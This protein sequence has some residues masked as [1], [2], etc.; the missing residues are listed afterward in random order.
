VEERKK[1]RKQE[2]GTARRQGSGFRVQ[3]RQK[4]RKQ[5][6]GSRNCTPA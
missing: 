6:A 1:D 3:E 4:D 5:E 2:A